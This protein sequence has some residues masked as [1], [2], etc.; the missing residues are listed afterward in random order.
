MSGEPRITYDSVSNTIN[1]FGRFDFTVSNKFFE[2]AKDLAQD[3]AVN[4]D[5]SYCNY[6]DSSAIG[7]LLDL[8]RYT[9]SLNSK[10]NLINCKDFVLEILKIA[11]FHKLF[12]INQK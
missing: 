9:G 8:K 10:I 2:L 3:E 7:A 1:I 4:V 6:I 5:L 11:D 12:N